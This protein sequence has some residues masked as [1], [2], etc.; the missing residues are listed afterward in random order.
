M[1]QL[2]RT[3]ISDLR[4]DAEV[5]V[6]MSD[7][8]EIPSRHTISLLQACDFGH[9]IHLQLRNF[10]YRYA[11]LSSLSLSA[12]ELVT[13]SIPSFE[14]Y[15]GPSSW[16]ASVHRWWPDAYY[17]HSQSSPAMLADSG[18]HCSFC[19][20]TIPEYVVKMKGFSHSDRIGGDLRLLDPKRIQDTICSGKDIFG[21][22]PEAYSVCDGSF[23]LF[24]SR[25]AY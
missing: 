1:T 16:R 2:L 18:W 12:A 24:S 7:V 22:L 13:D 17:R 3:T 21:M 20:R 23:Q 6:I 10:L 5:L 19:F 25:E 4:T 9:S 8:D 11:L 15:I 14:W